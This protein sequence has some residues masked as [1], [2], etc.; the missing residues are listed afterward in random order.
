MRDSCDAKGFEKNGSEWIVRI[1]YWDMDSDQLS[2][3]IFGSFWVRY[4]E[5]IIGHIL[6]E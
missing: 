2:W 1:G 5:N 6:N 4:I 3:I